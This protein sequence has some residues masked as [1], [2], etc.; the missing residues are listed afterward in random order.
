[1]RVL[2]PEEIVQIYPALFQK[3]FGK[4]I[5][6]QI[7]RTVI[8]QETEG[9]ITGFVSGYLID[10]ETFYMAWG[11]TT[12]K[13][14]KAKKFWE[15]GENKFKELGVKWFQTAVENVNTPWQRVLMGMGWIPFGIKALNNKLFIQYFKEL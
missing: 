12:G 14:V 1:M 7:P 5:G 4:S 15:K 2:T 3:I 13:F 6:N 11:G 10:T 9:E 8:V